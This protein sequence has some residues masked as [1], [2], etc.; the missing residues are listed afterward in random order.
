MWLRACALGSCLALG[1]APALPAAEAG[2][3]DPDVLEGIELWW[4]LGLARDREPGA[5]TTRWW[6][7]GGPCRPWTPRRLRLWPPRYRP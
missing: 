3:S 6:P 2:P 1:L 5:P 4:R 7:T